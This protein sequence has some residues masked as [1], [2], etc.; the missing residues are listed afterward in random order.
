MSGGAEEEAAEEAA[1]VEDVAFAARWTAVELE[2]L[3]EA[4]ALGGPV[5]FALS[6]ARL[7]AA[8]LSAVAAS[9]RGTRGVNTTE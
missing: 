5:F 9:S 4:E 6:R 2:T 8:I 1:A 3:A 7:L